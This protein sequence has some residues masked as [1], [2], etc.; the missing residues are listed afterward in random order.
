MHS[1]NIT[2]RTRLTIA[3]LGI[4]LVAAACSSET[5]QTDTTA[6]PTEV[7]TEQ[8]NDSG[9]VN[10][11]ATSEADDSLDPVVE[12]VALTPAP[13]TPTTTPDA[14]DTPDPVAPEPA[15]AADDEVEPPVDPTPPSA[16]DD[17]AVPP[18]DPTPPPTI[19]DLAATPVDP[20]EPPVV[21]DDLMAPDNGPACGALPDV[22]GDAVIGSDLW[23]D[24]DGGGVDDD[25]LVAYYDG[26]WK[27]RAEFSFGTQ[28]E[29]TIPG[30]G[31]SGVRVIGFADVDHTYGGEEILAVVGGGASTLEVGVFSFYEGGCIFRYAAEGG[32]DFGL[33]SGA[34]ITHGDG[35]ICSDGFITSW[36]YQQDGDDTYTV[37]SASFEPV[38]LGVFGYVPAS[39]GFAQG[40][41]F[42][43]ISTDLFDCNGLTL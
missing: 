22:S 3:A 32:G 19:D 36:G 20:P 16:A 42:D 6:A 14:P 17:V 5:V 18:V 15:P 41:S 38:S 37:S 23:Y 10:D 30:A 35:I 25:R 4:T 11:V 39:D 8:V 13:A 2:T 24:G 1:N 31:V 9:D 33:M 28:S 26:S 29:I 40:L 43:E 7:S 21:I 12:P 34:T 27:I